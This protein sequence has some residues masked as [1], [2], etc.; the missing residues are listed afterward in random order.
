MDTDEDQ[1]DYDPEYTLF[2]VNY[3]QGYEVED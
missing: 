3:G 2:E 1:N